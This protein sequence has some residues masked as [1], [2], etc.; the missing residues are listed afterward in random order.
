[1]RRS[2]GVIAL[3]G[4]DARTWR[5][6][7]PCAPVRAFPAVLVSVTL[8]CVLTI[9][10]ATTSPTH[11]SCPFRSVKSREHAIHRCAARARA[12]VAICAPLNRDVA[13]TC[14]KMTAPFCCAA[15]P[16]RELL[17][18][19]THEATGGSGRDPS[20]AT[21]SNSSLPVIANTTAMSDWNRTRMAAVRAWRL[22]M[23]STREVTSRYDFRVHQLH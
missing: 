15:Y 3:A 20:A 7:V 14:S 22:S 6:A 16:Q 13:A 10:L 19:D 18:P 17:P 2:T 11:G 8:H 23:L 4:D 5:A 21:T 9:L 1:M 12:R